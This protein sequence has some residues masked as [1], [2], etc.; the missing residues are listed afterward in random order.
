MVYRVMDS[1]TLIASDSNV[2]DGSVVSAYEKLDAAV[3][4][5]IKAI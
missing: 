2:G 5:G 1:H 3:K 4:A